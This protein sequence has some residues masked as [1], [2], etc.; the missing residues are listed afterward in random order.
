MDEHPG[1]FSLQKVA[2]SDSDGFVTVHFTYSDAMRLT[3]TKST[4]GIYYLNASLWEVVDLFI[5]SRAKLPKPR[6]PSLAWTAT[7]YSSI[8]YKR[9]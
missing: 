7:T 9:K 8:Q 4:N 3:K 6:C 2:G 1:A 5:R